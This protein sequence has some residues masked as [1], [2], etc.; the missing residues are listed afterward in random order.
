MNRSPRTLY[1][2]DLDGTLLDG[3]SRVSA[4]SAGL[5]AEM[6]RSGVLITAATARTPATV[7][8]LLQP[9]HIALPV[10]VMTGAATWDLASQQ[11]LQVHHLE[12][13]VA[14]GI[15]GI[16][17]RAGLNPL[18]YTL[19]S[20]SRVLQVYHS[21]DCTPQERHFID[22][23]R[24]LPLKRFHLD[25]HYDAA[26]G[27]PD[28]VL[29]FVMGQRDK[30]FGVADE[31]RALFGGRCSVSAYVDIFG[32]DTGILEVYGAGVSKAAA[33]LRLKESLR[34][35]RL[36]VFGDNLNDLPM[37]AV[38]DRSY[39]VANALAEVRQAAT[40]VIGYNTAD[41]VAR[42]IATLEGVN[43]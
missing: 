20:G 35:D 18:I 27:I 23:R 15:V 1:V 39:A 8:P 33:I 41:A 38:A 10:V 6:V 16:C 40:A 11:Y 3:C 43:F 28:T 37:M 2:T 32:A 26:D 14:A 17:R 9:A 4:T 25:Y 29:T 5:I 24:H 30:V 36:V 34:A 13:Q 7:Q 22:E 12:P 42:T 19:P 31:V 21:P